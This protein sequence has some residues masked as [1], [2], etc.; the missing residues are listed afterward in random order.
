MRIFLLRLTLAGFLRALI[1][2][3]LIKINDF[4]NSINENN[5]LLEKSFLMN[6]INLSKWK[7]LSLMRLKRIKY[8]P[9]S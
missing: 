5:E 1:D 9:K 3:K 7:K 8:W 4:I 2:L 6:M